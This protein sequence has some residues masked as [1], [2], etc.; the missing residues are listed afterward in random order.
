MAKGITVKKGCDDVKEHS[1]TLIN[2]PVT[3]P[4]IR[5]EVFGNTTRPNTA[6]LCF[7]GLC[8]RTMLLRAETE[9]T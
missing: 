9:P 3:Q 6:D 5:R 1:R 4:P 2:V 7:C 8:V